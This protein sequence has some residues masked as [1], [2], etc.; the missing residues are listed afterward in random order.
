MKWLKLP[1]HSTPLI[2]LQL[3]EALILSQM[4]LAQY[5]IYLAAVTRGLFII[6]VEG[7]STQA[8]TAQLL[9]YI[10][11]VVVLANTN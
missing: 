7:T 9:V 8:T 2:L 1:L 5:N 3:Y 10:Y 11:L 4:R 6:E